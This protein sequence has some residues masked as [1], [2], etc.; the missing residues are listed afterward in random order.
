MSAASP[1][2]IAEA[3]SLFERYREPVYRYCLS[4]LR[5]REEAED[6]LQTTF[7]R[8]YAALVRGVRPDCEA[9][10]LYTIAH[11]V[12]LS[13]CAA[14]A[15]RRRVE[16]ARDIKLLSETVAAPER[17]DVVPFRDALASL[18]P[19]VRRAL[20]LREWRGLSYQ[21]IATE[22]GTTVGAVESLIFRARRQLA[23]M[24]G[25]VPE[26]AAAAA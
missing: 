6:A 5:S 3:E 11:N 15:R 9:A 18:A 13:R 4:R 14:S 16:S 2:P 17:V 19:R 23:E 10:W 22:L 24:L 8:A 1:H 7:L 20:L 26:P 12:C 21:E 25:A